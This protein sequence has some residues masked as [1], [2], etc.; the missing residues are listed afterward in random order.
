MAEIENKV[1]TNTEDKGNKKEK[2][3]LRTIIVLA[4]LVLF[5]L[6]LWVTYRADYIEALEIGEIY[7]DTFTRNIR[8]KMIIGIANF[9]LIFIAVRNN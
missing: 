9:V 4:S 1:E 2:M 5:I 8:Y 6:G 7:V 3:R